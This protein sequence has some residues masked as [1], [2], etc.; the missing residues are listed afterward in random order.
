MG[1]VE[2]EIKVFTTKK[3]HEWM[4]DRFC[5]M[6]NENFHNKNINARI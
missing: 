2:C 5:W 4:C 3:D 1:Y 6:W